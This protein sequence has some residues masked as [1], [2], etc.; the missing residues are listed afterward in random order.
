MAF[1]AWGQGVDL[2]LLGGATGLGG[3]YLVGSNGFGNFSKN[4]PTFPGTRFLLNLMGASRSVFPN[5]LS[6]IDLGLNGFT[7]CLIY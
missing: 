5:E 6:T 3:T 2:F 1:S 4:I 7:I